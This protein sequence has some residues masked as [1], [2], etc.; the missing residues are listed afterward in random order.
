MCVCRVVRK[1]GLVGLGFAS[2]TREPLW[3]TTFNTEASLKARPKPE[4]AILSMLVERGKAPL[5]A[6]IRHPLWFW[7]VLWS[8]IVAGLCGKVGAPEGFP[9]K[10]KSL[11]KKKSLQET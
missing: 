4:T 10:L 1:P 5:Q 2:G 9:S 6:D 7:S 11:Y 8:G 3:C